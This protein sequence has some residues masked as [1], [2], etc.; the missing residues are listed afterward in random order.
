MITILVILFVGVSQSFGSFTED[1]YPGQTA[2]VKQNSTFALHTNLTFTAPTNG[3]VYR[4]Y[5][6]N[7]KLVELTYTFADITG[8]PAWCPKNGVC[9]VS[10]QDKY[11]CSG[12]GM[13]LIVHTAQYPDNGHY[14]FTCS[15]CK[16]NQAVNL[17][18]TIYVWHFPL[19]NM[20]L[21]VYA[22]EGRD[23]ILHADIVSAQF[24]G[25]YRVCTEKYP[26][27]TYA[28]N[29]SYADLSYNNTNEGKYSESKT[30]FDLLINNVTGTDAGYYLLVAYT[31]R[32]YYVV[33]YTVYVYTVNG[34]ACDQYSYTMTLN[35]SSI[36]TETSLA[37]WNRTDVCHNILTYANH[38]MTRGLHYTS[39]ALL[40]NETAGTFLINSILSNDMGIYTLTVRTPN[41]T[42]YVQ[43]QSLD[44]YKTIE[45]KTSAVGQSV[46]LTVWE[47][48][49]VPF[50]VVWYKM[51][52]NSYKMI[53]R[54]EN[55][56]ATYFRFG[57]RFMDGKWGLTIDS[58]NCT[59]AGIYIVDL[60][61]ITVIRFALQVNYTGRQCASRTVT[62]T[63]VKPPPQNVCV[64]QPIPDNLIT[65][66]HYIV[67]Y[68]GICPTTAPPPTTTT[69][70]MCKCKCPCTTQSPTL[71]TPHIDITSNGS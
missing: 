63:Y 70:R 4:W 31:E 13:T 9:G 15:N 28:F 10:G 20:T 17:T 60:N 59:D 19:T 52:T 27:V 22:F 68:S 23:L 46:D 49:A 33:S 32:E 62:V 30:A 29:E 12:R 39:R 25:W 67:L 53:A 71:T 45:N 2:D 64:E 8:T 55:G 69:K 57:I 1:V 44:M 54:L 42:D 16:D 50:T 11:T 51:E 40:V 43:E 34:F 61:Q 18:F 21:D 14:H 41:E 26:L 36:L 65:T 37:L 47:T 5:H 58:V 24:V 3:D 7:T 48:M 35:N 38:T 6:N 56:T 66:M